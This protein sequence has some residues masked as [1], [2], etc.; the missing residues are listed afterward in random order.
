VTDQS[1]SKPS[2]RIKPVTAVFTKT[3]GSFVYIDSEAP[4][5]V[6]VRHELDALHD[7]IEALEKAK[8]PF[9][10]V[11]GTDKEI[12][13][14][15][16]PKQEPKCEHDRGGSSGMWINLESTLN[17]ALDKTVFQTCPYCPTEKKEKLDFILLQVDCSSPDYY[18]DLSKVCLEAVEKVIEKWCIEFGLKQFDRN[19]LREYLRKELL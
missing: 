13:I 19:D 3:D 6:D 9:Y 16:K 2:E 11:N 8:P 15:M 7:R 4:K 12:K 5:I 14:S 1:K 18:K 17:P 10:V